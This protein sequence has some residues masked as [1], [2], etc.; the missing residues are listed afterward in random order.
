MRVE[1]V[2]IGCCCPLSSW[3]R[4]NVA[5]TC[6]SWLV[7][8]FE[9]QG[10]TLR[11]VHWSTACTARIQGRTAPAE[12]EGHGTL[13]EILEWFFSISFFLFF[14]FSFF[15]FLFSF[16]F[17]LF[18]FSFLLFSFLF[19][20]FS[21]A[22]FSFSPSSFLFPFPFSLFSFPFYLSLFLFPLFLLFFSSPSPPHM[23]DLARMLSRKSDGSGL[24]SR[25]NHSVGAPVTEIH[26]DRLITRK[27]QGKEVAQSIL[28]LTHSKRPSDH[29]QCFTALVS[30]FPFS[31]SCCACQA[32]RQNGAP[33]HSKENGRRSSR[34]KGERAHVT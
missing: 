7:G 34:G 24:Q 20:F 29:W 5:W 26:S 15:L 10:S 3:F 22:L 12:V 18:P 23:L 4:M 28:D 13:L 11:R 33:L 14:L 27:K 17:F 2:I 9:M 8:W 31:R 16:F 6:R 30:S 1:F 19:S 21:F 25:I 32:G